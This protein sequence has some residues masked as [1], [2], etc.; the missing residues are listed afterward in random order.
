[1]YSVLTTV[2]SLMTV[3]VAARHRRPLR[4]AQRRDDRVERRRP[5]R[6]R[7]GRRLLHPRRPHRVQ[8][9]G[10]VTYVDPVMVLVTCAA[11]VPAPIGTV[12]TTVVELLEWA[13]DEA[14]QGSVLD[15]IDTISTRFR[16]D[17][18][19]VRMTKVGPKL[20]VEIEALVDRAVTVA[21]EQ[22]VRDELQTR[23]DRPPY[24]IWLTVTLAPRPPDAR[25]DTDTR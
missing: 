7:H 1:V 12:R 22:H 17:P 23:L 24:K 19:E 5:A 25:T 3:A 18:P 16:I 15:T 21:H 11:S 10:A 13:P 9:D 2:A 4:P 20:H 8:L 6:R 14:I